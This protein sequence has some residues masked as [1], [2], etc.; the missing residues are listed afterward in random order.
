MR[1]CTSRGAAVFACPEPIAKRSTSWRY[2][3]G[4]RPRVADGKWMA[5]GDEERS[6]PEQGMGIDLLASGPHPSRMGA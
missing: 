6:G 5:E 3:S 2:M 4:S 1:A